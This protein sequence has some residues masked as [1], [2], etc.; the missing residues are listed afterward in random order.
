[1]IATVRHIVTYAEL[2]TLGFIALFRCLGLVKPKLT[3]QL[4]SKPGAIAAVIGFIWIYIIL[5]LMPSYLN[6]S[7]L[8]LYLLHM[9][10]S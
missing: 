3:N 8:T 7:Q 6:V 10:G 9:L 4:F 2:L 1:M 5:L